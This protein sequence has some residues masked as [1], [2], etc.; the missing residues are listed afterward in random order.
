MDFVRLVPPSDELSL[1]EAI[2]DFARLSQERRL[3]LGLGASDY[4][5]KNY[6]I[7]SMVDNHIALYKA[8][9]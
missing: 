9:S 3:E 1:A 4:V 8:V 5:R 7:D 2:M 6:S